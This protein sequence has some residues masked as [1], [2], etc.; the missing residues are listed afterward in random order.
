MTDVEREQLTRM[1]NLFC[2]LHYI[3]GLADSAEECL[4]LWEAHSTG[5]ESC[6]SS[7]TQ[8]LIRTACKALHHRGSQQCGS[9]V[10]FRTYLRKHNIHKIPLAQFVGNRFNVLFYDAAGVY[11]LRSYMTDFIKSV[12]GSQSNRLLKAVKTDFEEPLHVAGCRALGLIDKIVTGP[13]WRQLQESASSILKM[14]DI[15]C[16]MKD[17][18]DLWSDDPHGVVEGTAILVDGMIVHQDDVWSALC[19]S[20]D[21]DVLTQEILQLL[22]CAFS[23]TTQ[24]L[25]LDHLPGGVY[26]S[27]EDTVIM[28]ETASV[29]YT[30]VAPERDFAMLDRLIREKPNA[31]MAALEAMILYSHNKSSKWHEQQSADDRGNLLKAARTLAPL[32]RAKFRRR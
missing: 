16:K 25:L 3:V 11:Y 7:G 5:N 6:S 20:N 29:P 14:G 27:C 17:K 8:R 24:R 19:S 30:N 21:T 10:L 1:Y 28:S 22:F 26:Y 4:K 18:F 2:G 12:H 9:S 13:L 15:Y 31:T 32:I 23:R